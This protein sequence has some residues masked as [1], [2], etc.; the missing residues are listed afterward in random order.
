MR[1]ALLARLLV[2]A[3]GLSFGLSLALFFAAAPCAAA[4]DTGTYRI[5]DYQV[6]LTPAPDGKVRI[7]YRQTWLVESGHI[8]WITIGTPASRFTLLEHGIDAASASNA[9]E[10][11]WSGVRLDLVR[12]Y[13]PGETFTVALS[14]ATENLIFR[15]RTGVHLQFTPGW[16]DRARTDSLRITLRHFAVL[17]SVRVKPPADVTGER[18][19]VWAKANLS[20]G[21]RFP[22]DLL[23]PQSQWPASQPLPAAKG[24]TGAGPTVAIGLGLVALVV[25]LVLVR[26]A[27][28]GGG[29]GRYTGGGLY[30][31]GAT[32]HGTGVT[33]ADRGRAC[34]CACVAC[35][36]ACACAGGGGAGCAR[37]LEVAPTPR[38]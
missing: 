9:S 37:K 32:F 36:C 1:V 28:G 14:I 4:Q 30:V 23:F 16:Y 26:L 22:I 6:M 27:R 12:D 3:L 24:G 20:P 8:P 17:D 19:L 7:D 10:G 15:R 2:F 34:A 31:P 38:R 11:S 35:A 33:P 25:V 18:E 21:E 5:L 13:R 29:R